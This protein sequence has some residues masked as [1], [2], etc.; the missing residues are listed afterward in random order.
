MTSVIKIVPIILLFVITTN[1]NCIHAQENN[2]YHLL[3]NVSQSSFLNPAVQNKTDKLI[4]SVPFFSG[5]SFSYNPNFPINA[6]FSNGF[7]N[8]SFFDFYDNLPEFG[9]GQASLQFTMFYASLNYSDYTFSVSLAD[10]VYATTHFDREIVRIIKDGIAPY[11]KKDTDFG[12]GSFHFNHFRELAFGIS[13]R[14]WKELDIGLRPKIL[15]GRTYFDAK[16]VNFSVETDEDEDLINLK[17]EGSF[18]VSAPVTYARDS[19]FEY[20]YFTAAFIPSDY[21]FNLRNI[22]FALDLGL[23]YRPNK[24]YE[25]SASLIDLVFTGYKHNTFKVNFVDPLQY[26]YPILYQSHSP[27]EDLYLESR[28]A[29]REFS[30]SVSYIINVFDQSERIFNL[31]PFKINVSGKYNL[32]ESL[33]FGMANKFSYYGQHSVNVLSGFMHKKFEKTNLGASISTY[34]FS[35]IWVG[36]GASYTTKH[37]QYYISSSNIIG[38]ILPASTKRLNL[39]LGINLLFTT[40]KE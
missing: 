32:S 5:T 17:P 6:L 35:D 1:Q 38:I 13:Q 39:S 30:D 31:M 29:L 10:R 21:A 11:Y 24:F 12:K 40:V 19:I 15:F 37:F 28:E 23:V 33:S 9:K 26:K 22:G 14:Y 34:N 25:L 20:T 27:G 2:P 16:D 3:P 7:W 8:Y 36:L 4:I 18:N